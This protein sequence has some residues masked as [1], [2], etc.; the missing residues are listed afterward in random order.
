MLLNVEF[1]RFKNGDC[2]YSN[3]NSFESN[4]Q[5]LPKLI[6][7]FTAQVKNTISTNEN[8]IY[9]SSKDKDN[10]KIIGAD[11]FCGSWVDKKAKRNYYWNF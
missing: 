8:N 4:N 3:I 7:V 10:F 6:E 5:N 9:Y 11:M 1:A 2:Q